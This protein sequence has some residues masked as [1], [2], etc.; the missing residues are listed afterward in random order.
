[1][2]LLCPH[3]IRQKAEQAM[4]GDGKWIDAF[5]IGNV[6]K[7]EISSKRTLLRW[8]HGGRLLLLYL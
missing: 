2:F 6:K 7:E 8:F 3:I 1:M 5:K 4:G